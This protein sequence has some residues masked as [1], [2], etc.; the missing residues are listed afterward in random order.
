MMNLNA[1][2]SRCNATR[3]KSLT[4]SPSIRNFEAAGTTTRLPVQDHNGFDVDFGIEAGRR[5]LDRPSESYGKL[6]LIGR[7][8][9]KARE[10]AGPTLALRRSRPKKPQNFWKSEAN[11]EGLADTS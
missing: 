3:P 11:C 9:G 7:V 2:Q 4:I 10:A 5:Q 8:P 6:Y 1:R